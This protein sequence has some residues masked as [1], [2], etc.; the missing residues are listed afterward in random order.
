MIK[1]TVTPV[2]EGYLKEA[3]AVLM[4]Y[5]KADP[6][7]P[8]E[9][10]ALQN[11][12]D[13]ILKKAPRLSKIFMVALNIPVKKREQMWK[14]RNL[15]GWLPGEDDLEEK[16]DELSALLEK[17]PMEADI[18]EMGWALNNQKEVLREAIN[19]DKKGLREAIKLLKDYVYDEQNESFAKLLAGLV[20][21][22]SPRISAISISLILE[23]PA[24]VRADI[25]KDKGGVRRFLRFLISHTVK[26]VFNP[27]KAFLS[28][29]QVK[30]LQTVLQEILDTYEGDEI[31]F[32]KSKAT[33]HKNGSVLFAL[34]SRYL[35]TQICTKIIERLKIPPGNAQ[36]IIKDENGIAVGL[37]DYL[38]N[39]KYPDFFWKDGEDGL[40]AVLEQISKDPG[41]DEE[42]KTI[43]DVIKYLNEYAETQ[44]ELRSTNSSEY[45]DWALPENP[46]K[47]STGAPLPGP[48]DD[49][50]LVDPTGNNLLHHILYGE[51]AEVE[52]IITAA[53]VKK[54]DLQQL[55][56][57]EATAS[58]YYG[59]V[60]TSSPW[61]AVFTT[62]DSPMRKWIYENCPEIREALE[63]QAQKIPNRIE[64]GELEIFDISPAIKNQYDNFFACVS[65][66][67]KQ[68]GFRKWDY[69]ELG[70]V[71]NKSIRAAQRLLPAWLLEVM[72]LPKVWDLSRNDVDLPQR[73]LTIASPHY[74]YHGP[75][76]AYVLEF[77]GDDTGFAL[78]KGERKG[79]QMINDDLKVFPPHGCAH[80]NRMRFDQKALL[81]T[82]NK[83]LKDQEQFL[84]SLNP[85]PEQDSTRRLSR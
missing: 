70:N 16:K 71:F 41:S 46:K 11:Q 39:K 63:E 44:K 62:V 5:L 38:Q 15:L 64:Q 85:E 34:E 78:V 2:E 3:V 7:P 31:L 56:T 35:T 29:N 68:R 69:E 60:V 21:C 54:V 50:L 53:K 57:G 74:R 72:L 48:E 77:L 33:F 26:K 83:S 66:M 27:Y 30:P 37:V 67:E 12:L 42:K 28:K 13:T 10:E 14:Y 40:R 25:Q 36:R 81:S 6:F 55:L 73:C 80:S 1:N 75:Q 82:F 8:F 19:N 43:G 24:G 45:I 51:Q 23:L 65:E 32:K 58:T 61:D 84:S 47:T 22:L 52:K 17:L 9:Y 4:S 18:S 20:E 79:P 59:D 76:P 49:P